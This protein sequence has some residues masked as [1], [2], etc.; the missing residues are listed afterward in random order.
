MDVQL[1]GFPES[2]SSELIHLAVAGASRLCDHTHGSESLSIM[3][4]NDG[5]MRMGRTYGG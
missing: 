2:D 3:A 5:R 1:P 4:V